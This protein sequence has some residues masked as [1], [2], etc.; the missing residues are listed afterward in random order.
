M[1]GISR[2]ISG[3]CV[4]GIASVQFVL[5]IVGFGAVMLLLAMGPMFLFL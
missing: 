5:G 1:A 4:F 3:V 2:I